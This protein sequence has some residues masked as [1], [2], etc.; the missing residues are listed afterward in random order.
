MTRASEDAMLRETGRPETPAASGGGRVSDAPEAARR[1]DRS[2]WGVFGSSRSTASVDAREDAREGAIA[3][4]RDGA[5]SSRAQQRSAW[6]L[7]MYVTAALAL[8]RY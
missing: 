6:E 3:R 2:R 7:P 5:P 4:S 8:N 1:R